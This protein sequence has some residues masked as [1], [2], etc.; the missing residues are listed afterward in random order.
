[1]K[2]F[3]PS[4]LL[5]F[6]LI[7][8]PVYGVFY[9]T[10]GLVNYG[11]ILT[12]WE[13]ISSWVTAI[14]ILLSM[15]WYGLG[16]AVAELLALRLCPKQKTNAAKHPIFC[17]L[18]IGL[19][20]VILGVAVDILSA[21]N[22]ISVMFA[23]IAKMLCLT[24]IWKNLKNS[25]VEPT[26]DTE[27]FIWWSSLV[28]VILAFAVVAAM[29]PLFRK[30]HDARLG[31]YRTDVEYEP[32]YWGK[33]LLRFVPMY[34]LFGAVAV[35]LAWGGGLAAVNLLHLQNRAACNVLILAQFIL[36]SAAI[37][38]AM[39]M[40]YTQ[41][42]KKNTEPEHPLAVLVATGGILW[43]MISVIAMRDF[44]QNG[45]IQ[46]AGNYADSDEKL[47][48]HTVCHG[49]SVIGCFLEGLLLL[50]G[51]SVMGSRFAEQK[52]WRQ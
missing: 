45:M 5:R 6:V 32:M 2:R 17:Y 10:A 20:G 9:V 40:A 39:Y 29:T 24:V 37:L 23:N 26:L 28:T 42:A 3:L 34:M 35:L 50:I 18:S 12:K 51:V 25:S 11:M 41:L 13:S 49:V 15:L 44:V 52:L 19:C 33:F 46:A 14:A 36:S 16:V 8:F 1:M 4:F 21:Y 31:K 7:F 47:M 48:I 22:D 30:R 38:L 43:L 27:R